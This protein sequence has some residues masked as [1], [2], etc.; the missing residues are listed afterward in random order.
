MTDL[1]GANLVA[2]E[3]R[4][5]GPA[6]IESVDPWTGTVRDSRTHEATP[7]EVAAACEAAATAASSFAR[8]APPERAELLREIADALDAAAADIVVLADGE[9]GLGTRPRLEGELARTT[10]QLRFLADVVEEGS[11]L[12]AS[13]DHQPEGP[14][15]RRLMVPLGPVAVF[16]ASNF[17]LAFSVAGGDTGSGLAAGCPVVVKAH[18][19]HPLTSELVGRVVADAV[20]RAGAPPGVFSLVHGLDAGR[21][22]VLDPRVRAVAF[23]GSFP[24]GMAIAEL[25][26]GRDDPIPVYAE[27]GSLN[28]VVVTAE[29]ARARGDE[30]AEGFAGSMTLGAGQFCT[31]PGLLFVPADVPEL[32]SAIVE[33]LAAIRTAPMLNERIAVGWREGVERWSRLG[34]VEVLVPL[35][36]VEGEGLTARPALV[37]TSAAAFAGSEPLHEECFGPVAVLVR[38]HGRDDL[39]AALRTVPG[40]LVAGIHG[41][42]GDELVDDL[43]DALSGTA[44]RLVWNGWPTGVAVLWSMHHGGPFPATTDPLHTSVGATSLRRFLRPVAYQ[45]AP[46]DLLPPPVRDANPWGV[47]QRVEGELRT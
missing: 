44:G 46:D 8:T 34:E 22:L 32:G 20:R 45:G 30:I 47:P 21:W 17:P 1:N 38:Y 6:T 24:G 12:E 42:A 43:L 2:G 16:A 39:L 18:P 15:I 36:A 11:W 28:P 33:R 5:A 29:A 13:I 19:S 41:S 25:A 27:M 4:S 31:K 10:G 7:D 26:A 37:A 35:A 9:T 23:T 40:S 14:T 3:E